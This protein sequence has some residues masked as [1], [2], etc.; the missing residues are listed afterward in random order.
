LAFRI[1]NDF[2]L[3]QL[4]VKKQTLQKEHRQTISPQL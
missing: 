4:S 1:P 2:T 3:R